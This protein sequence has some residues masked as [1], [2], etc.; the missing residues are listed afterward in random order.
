MPGL[1]QDNSLSPPLCLTFVRST[2]LA[3]S[4]KGFP[5]PLFPTT[6]T[7]RQ[8]RYPHFVAPSCSRASSSCKQN[9][10]FANDAVAAPVQLRAIKPPDFPEAA[11][12]GGQG[13]RIVT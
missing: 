1:T 2:V 9:E 11:E 3:R 4:P 12:A 13:S 5:C 7:A 8:R 10:S 6:L